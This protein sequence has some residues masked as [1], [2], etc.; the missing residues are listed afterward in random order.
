MKATK[1]SYLE[2]LGRLPATLS[3]VAI[4]LV[5]TWMGV[6]S[7]GYFTGDWSLAVLMLALLALIN[8]A[9]GAFRGTRLRYGT[10]AL[11]AFGLY[12]TWTFASILWS[13]NRGNAWLG[14][15]QT[16]LYF[17]VV[18]VTVSLLVVG[19]SR[20]WVLA[21]TALGPA[22]VAALTFFSIA[23]DPGQLFMNGRL[24]GTV[25]YYN[26][27]A[28][29]LL[30]PFWTAIYLA[31][32]RRVNPAL[33]GLVLAGAVISAEVAVL[34]QSRG[35]MVAMVISLLVFFLLS[36]QRL[37]GL[38][39]L[40][41]VAVAL[42]LTFPGLNDVYLAFSEGGDPVAALGRV[43]PTVWLVS[44][45]AGLYAGLWGLIDLWW[46]PPE[47]AVRASGIVALAAVVVVV[48]GGLF[49][50]TERVGNPVDLAQQ[51]WEAFKTSDTTGQQQSRYL[52]A[53][54]QG[55]YSLWKI[56]WKDFT[57]H[58]VLGVGTQNYE[59][60]YYQKR[61]QTNTG[62]VRQPHMLPLE[63]LGERG[64][65]G[66]ILFF[67]FLGVSAAAGLRERFGRL[68]SEGKAQ[69]GALMAAIAYWFVHS[70]ADWFWQLPAVT[71]P[72]MV[73]LGMLVT[74]WRRSETAPLGWPLRS[75]GI[76]AAALALVAVFPLYAASRYLAQTYATTNASEGLAAIKRA[77]MFDPLDPLL[78]QREAE[79]GQQLREPGLAGRAYRESIRLNPEHYAPYALLASFEEQRG[80]FKKSLSLYQKALALNPLSPELNRQ[81][82]QVLHQ[83][84]GESVTVRFMEWAKTKA[85]LDL[86]IAD[87]SGQG[88]DNPVKANAI[89]VGKDGVLYAWS[90]N[91]RAP[92][93]ASGGASPA[94][95]IAF[96]NGNGEILAIKQLSSSGAETV[97]PT[98]SYRL[99]IEARRGFFEKN[100]I[101]PSDRAIFAAKSPGA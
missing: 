93:Y 81:E 17:L 72:A 64:V 75:A 79:L 58:P 49:V 91:A 37:R 67:V 54:G 96:L 47:V 9:T 29:F 101:G 28:A 90:T 73:Y 1:T 55:R 52:S 92:F 2:R 85:S 59:A 84:P 71:L 39:S 53:S 25:G 26:G 34:S 69:V 38:I 11:A 24:N 86:K 87:T 60:T 15:G 7:G 27:E 76:V 41:P 82:I 32:S 62:S 80:R 4:G 45:G 22:V 48:V 8:Y 95:D 10:V 46:R 18:L 30:V 23:S 14:A 78:R 97:Q 100:G 77:E 70:S 83:A 63:V 40:V 13:P 57:S 68:S 88:V 50:V 74:P 5:A 21:A 99:A 35:A 20:R 61:G 94:V 16:L 12:A 36:G 98:G 56:A 43:A 44:A 89:P 31:S 19:A 3:L 66:G 51:K 33:R 65:V 42:F 6:A